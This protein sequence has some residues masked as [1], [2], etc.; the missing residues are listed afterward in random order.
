MSG[1]W[2]GRG[3]FTGSTRGM[4]IEIAVLVGLAG[5]AALVAFIV[6]ILA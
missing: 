2:I 5:F 3:A 6:S 4:L 1:P